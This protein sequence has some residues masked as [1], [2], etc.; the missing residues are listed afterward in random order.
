M[1]HV[2]H[3]NLRPNHVRWTGILN[4]DCIDSMIRSNTLIEGPIIFDK[5]RVLNF[6]WIVSIITCQIL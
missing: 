1:S 6:D 5:T 2:T 4:F 3:F